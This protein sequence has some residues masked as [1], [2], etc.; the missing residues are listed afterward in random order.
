MSPL[1]KINIDIY[2]AD[3]EL[4]ESISGPM[5]YEDVREQMISIIR[6]DGIPVIRIAGAK[7]RHVKCDQSERICAE[8]IDRHVAAMKDSGAQLIAHAAYR[9]NGQ[10]HCVTGPAS[11]VRAQIAEAA[12]RAKK[13]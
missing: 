12:K 10:L 8:Q 2:D 7:P 5:D 6:N 3:G 11:W 13:S 1:Q 9:V 4:C